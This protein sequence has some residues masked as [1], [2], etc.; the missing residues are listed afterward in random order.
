[1]DISNMSP[2]QL[3]VMLNQ[4]SNMTDDQI[5]GAIRLMGIDMDIPLLRQFMEQMKS[6]TDEDF[7]KFKQQY[8]SGK[9]NMNEFKKNPFQKY[10]DKLK[11][12][13]SLTEQNKHIESIEACNNILNDLKNE[14]VEE[15]DN[16]KLTKLKEEIY[17]QLTLSRMNTQDLDLTIKECNDALNEVK[18]FSIYNRLGIA[19]FKKGRY[20]KS[21][22][23]FKKAKESFPDKTDPIAEK[24]LKMA[25]EEIENY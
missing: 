22:D 12:A 5:K 13:K 9:I 20:T 11:E 7:E 21:R 10:E 6:A 3:R 2:A 23:A 14:K 1:M 15:K 8:K 17:E 24:Y 4:F 19:F 18:V 16:D 25:L